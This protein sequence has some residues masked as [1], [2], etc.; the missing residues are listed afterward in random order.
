MI[1]VNYDHNQARQNLSCTHDI[2][3][4]FK[5]YKLFK[6]DTGIKRLPMESRGFGRGET[7]HVVSLAYPYR[8][9]RT[10]TEF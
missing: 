3:H 1:R 6:L 9:G 2:G 5:S 4:T 10:K 8:Q 7:R